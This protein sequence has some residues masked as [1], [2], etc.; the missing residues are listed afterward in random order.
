MTIVRTREELKVAQESGV[1]E[2][3]VIGDLAEKLKK[4]KKV[5]GL[6]GAALATLGAAIGIATVTAPAT[7][8]LSYVAF[9]TSAAPVAAMTGLEIAAIIYA[10]FLGI[11]LLIALFK[12]YE[13]ISF[14]DGKMILKKKAK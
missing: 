8:G 3:T 13:E 14:E 11:G 1:P 9:A 5:A 10:A 2:I 4:A 7:G 6:G 12:D